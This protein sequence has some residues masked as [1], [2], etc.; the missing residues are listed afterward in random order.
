MEKKEKHL[1]L[2]IPP[3]IWAKFKFVSKYEGR[4]C[5]SQLQFLVRQNIAEY[6]KEHGP[7]TEKDLA[8][9]N[10]FLDD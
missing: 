10:I 8:E 6:E 9:Y 5:N 1:G 2:R 4:S 3:A 7:I